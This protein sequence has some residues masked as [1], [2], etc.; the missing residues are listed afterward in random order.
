L[1]KKREKK[2][3]GIVEQGPGL[4]SFL[5]YGRH[6][7]IRLMRLLPSHNNRKAIDEKT[8]QEKKKRE[9]TDRVEVATVLPGDRLPW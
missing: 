4:L 1:D 9:R 3:V 7:L 2:S 6:Q 8:Q 5:A